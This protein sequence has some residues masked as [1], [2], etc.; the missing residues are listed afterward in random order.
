MIDKFPEEFEF[1]GFFEADPVRLSSGGDVVLYEIE[2]EEGFKLRFSFDII[3]GSIQAVV[4]HKDHE[5]MRFSQEFAKS[6]EIFEKEE[7]DFMICRFEH[8]DVSTVSTIQIRP[9]IK[10]TCATLL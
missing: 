4:Q 6:I 1:I 2:D 9:F 5:V 10:I 8:E 3:E 7:S